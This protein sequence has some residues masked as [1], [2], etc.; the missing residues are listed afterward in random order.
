MQLDRR[1][2]HPAARARPDIAAPIWLDDMDPLC[3]AGESR[4]EV[5]GVYDIGG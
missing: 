5:D 1:T 3:L 2:S 4:A